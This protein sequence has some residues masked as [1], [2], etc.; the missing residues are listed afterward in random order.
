[1]QSCNDCGW[2]SDDA[3]CL[4]G[5][6]RQE[7]SRG[8]FPRFLQLADGHEQ[9][10]RY[11]CF[12]LQPSKAEIYWQSRISERLDLDCHF[13]LFADRIYEP[14]VRKQ[15]TVQWSEML[16]R[17]GQVPASTHGPNNGYLD[18]R[19]GGTRWKVAISISQIAIGIFH[20]HNPS[21][22]TMALE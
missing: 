14:F 16:I 10:A 7:Q 20:W 19:L 15:Y 18:C 8:L 17:T 6:W 4:T 12:R 13:I 9:Q 2:K 21:G 11:C 5:T 3:W 1:M 22:R